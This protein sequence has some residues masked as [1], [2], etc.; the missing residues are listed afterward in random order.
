MY[1]NVD[2]KARHYR[3][4]YNM[5]EINRQGRQ[6]VHYKHVENMNTLSMCRH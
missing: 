6:I 3:L 2:D 5:R 1:D 4:I